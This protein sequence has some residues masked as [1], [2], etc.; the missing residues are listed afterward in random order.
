VRER[1]LPVRQAD[2]KLATALIMAFFAPLLAGLLTGS[3]A[4]ANTI[5]AASCNAADVQAAINAAVDGDTVAV[6]SGTCSWTTAVSVGVQTGWNPTV[7]QGMKAITLQGQT[8]CF[9]TPVSSCSDTTA[10][11]LNVSGSSSISLWVSPTNFVRLTGFTFTITA[12]Y[13]YN[14][15][16][17]FS[18][19]SWPPGVDFRLDHNHF[20]FTGA[21]V[22]V[23]VASAYGLADHN[24]F[25]IGSA[26]NGNSFAFHG[27]QG[28]GGFQS[29]Q[30]PMAL[31]SI[32]AIY[33]EDSSFNCSAYNTEAP[34]DAY[35]GARFVFRHNRVNSCSGLGGHGTDSGG[36]RSVFSVEDYDN[37]YANN[38]GSSFSPAYYSRGGTLLSWSNTYAGTPWSGISLN[39]YRC[40]AE[41]TD[42]GQWG[43]ADGTPWLLGSTDP[44]ASAGRINST[45]SPDWQANYSYS[46]LAYILPLANNSASYNYS[47]QGAC[48]SGSS[49]PSF[50]QTIGGTTTDG[51]CTWLNEGGGPAG[52]GAHWCV[53]NRDAPAMADS[54]CSAITPGDT[55]STFF[56]GSGA[57]GY[58]GRDQPGRT[59]NQALAPV[60]EW[61]NSLDYGI[62]GN[63][64]SYIAANRDYYVYTSNFNGSS[65]V[66]SGTL[67]QRPT[68]CTPLVAYWATDTSTLYQCTSANAW[69]AYYTP[70]VYPHPLQGG[71]SNTQPPSTPSGSIFAPRAYPNPWRADRGYVQQVTFDQ[72]SGN[73][74]IKI[75][76]VSGHLVRTLTTG[77]LSTTWD[78]N[79][80]SGDRVASGIYIYLAT[81]DQGQKAQGKVVVIR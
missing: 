41:V 74:T 29:W 28:S 33:V 54:T 20:I 57:G 21:A 73:T 40:G 42:T 6:P 52:V 11:T 63:P 10:I 39:C 49:E 23:L 78:I 45:D 50:N 1:N 62:G 77:S 13:P 70:Y 81:N 61:L 69:T 51:S 17:G 58:P 15:E 44:T 4:Q 47:A 37:A 12:A 67:A 48:T 56:D 71:S 2:G 76:T 55:A 7:I 35:T 38:L 59:H 16:I 75:F 3:A 36:Y 79:N 53:I 22:A 60:Y 66:G 68:T 43:I 31:G 25:D 46:N 9:G 18:G 30:T 5:P 26:P 27:D 34:V 14:G 65:G 72:L 80:D 8:V 24:L 64:S 19:V 32:D